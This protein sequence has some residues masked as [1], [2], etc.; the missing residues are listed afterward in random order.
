MRSS[1]STNTVAAPAEGFR[2]VGDD[3][4]ATFAGRSLRSSVSG[5][6]VQYPF[7]VDCW[8]RHRR[9]GEARGVL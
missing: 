5:V 2:A 1:Q 7:G 8:S 4:R 9:L 3:P 6:P